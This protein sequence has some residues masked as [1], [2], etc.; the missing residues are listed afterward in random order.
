MTEIEDQAMT[1]YFFWLCSM[2]RP[3][4]HYDQL[5]SRHL[6]GLFDLLKTHWPKET[7]AAFEDAQTAVATAPAGS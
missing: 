6:M 2:S 1:V 5:F 3:G 7:T 4:G